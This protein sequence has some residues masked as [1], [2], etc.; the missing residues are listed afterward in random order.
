[1]TETADWPESRPPAGW[2]PQADLDA[3]RTQLPFVYVDVLPVRVD[4]RGRVTAFGL[5]LRATDAGTLSRALVGGRVRH[6]EPLRDAI[7]RHIESDLG[8]MAFA[9][10]P[11][12]PQPFTVAEYLP[13]GGSLHDPRQHA[14]ALAY[15]VPVLGDCVPTKDVLQL[16]WVTPEDSLTPRIQADMERGQGVLL[17]RAVGHLGLV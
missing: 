11:P 1:M 8:R 9:Q 14:V 16:D 6:G 7:A 5:L 3:A 2:L 15:I 10:I 13:T 17:R 4:D 12:A